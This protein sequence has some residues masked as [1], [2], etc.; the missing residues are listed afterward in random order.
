MSVCM[1]YFYDI[2]S[3]WCPWLPV[4][5]NYC[6]LATSLLFLNTFRWN[7]ELVFIGLKNKITELRLTELRRTRSFI[8]I[9]SCKSVACNSFG[10]WFQYWDFVNFENLLTFTFRTTHEQLLCKLNVHILRFLQDHVNC[11]THLSFSKFVQGVNN[12]DM[13]I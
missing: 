8:G 10:K 1:I 3:R 12:A 6:W 2:H 5:S 7:R 9:K 4:L 11:E 13:L